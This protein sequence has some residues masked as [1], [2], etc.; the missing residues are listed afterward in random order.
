[1]RHGTDLRAGTDLREDILQ[2]CSLVGW[3]DVRII[4]GPACIEPTA[5]DTVEV[6]PQNIGIEPVA[7]DDRLGFFERAEFAGGKLIKQ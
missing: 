7:H 2:G 4:G 6:R 5:V 1:M 3:R